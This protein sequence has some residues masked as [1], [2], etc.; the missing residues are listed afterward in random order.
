MPSD[1]EQIIFSVHLK[2]WGDTSKVPSSVAISSTI[3][4]AASLKIGKKLCSV[5]ILNE[6]LKNFRSRCHWWKRDAR[7]PLL[8]DKSRYAM[9][10]FSMHSSALSIFWNISGVPGAMAMT[11][12]NQNFI[13]LFVPSAYFCASFSWSGRGNLFKFLFFVAA[14]YSPSVLSPMTLCKWPIIG[15]E[16]GE[17]MSNFIFG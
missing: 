14:N 9:K 15:I 3:R 1:V 2:M 16:G 8:S 6:L 7:R 17:G 13:N 12:R 5:D 10:G 11:F 4:V